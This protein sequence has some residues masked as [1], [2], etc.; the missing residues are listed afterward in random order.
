LK[1]SKITFMRDVFFS[2]LSSMMNTVMSTP[3]PLDY[4][5]TGK[6]QYNFALRVLIGY[7]TGQKIGELLV[8]TRYALMSSLSIYTNI[9]KLLIEK[10]GPPYCNCLEVWIVNR[11]LERLLLINQKVKI[12]GITQYPIEM[13]QNKRKISTIGGHIS[14]PSLWGNYEINDMHELLDET[15]IYVHTMKEPSNIHHE[16]I[17]AVQTILKFQAE[18][19]KLP[20]YRKK[21]ILK[22]TDDL[23][24][25]LLSDSIVGCCSN[26]IIDSTKHTVNKEKPFFKKNCS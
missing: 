1:L 15:F 8:D 12:D 6:L 4:I 5:A 7:A 16:N 10:F 3:I 18:F 25:F 19:D 24:N 26:V 17:K 20:T 14:L 23:D 2:T 22:T 21:G 13:E 9:Q 11:L